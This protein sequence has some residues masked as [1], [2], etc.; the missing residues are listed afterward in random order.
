M[1]ID[2]LG[3]VHG[4]EALTE[5]LTIYTKNVYRKV[6]EEM[7]ASPLSALEKMIRNTYKLEK[8]SDALEI[9]SDGDTLNVKISYCPAVKHLRKTGREVSEW[10]SYSTEIVMRTLAQKANLD[11]K[12]KS[13]NAE[14]GAAEYSFTKK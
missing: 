13:Y 12:F 9:N 4:V 1:G 5:Y 10:F 8:A 6:I 2:Y 11:F 14:S 7:K 3:K